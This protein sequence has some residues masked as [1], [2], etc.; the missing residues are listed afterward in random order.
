MDINKILDKYS[1]FDLQFVKDEK[2]ENKTY[3]MLDGYV[4]GVQYNF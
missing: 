3:I 2:D 4:I 1:S